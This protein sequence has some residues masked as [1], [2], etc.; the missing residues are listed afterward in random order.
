MHDL[1]LLFIYS[2][3]YVCIYIFIYINMYFTEGLGCGL[4]SDCVHVLGL[5]RVGVCHSHDYGHD[6]HWTGIVY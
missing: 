3:V 2:F 1:G 6:L 5:L 4:V